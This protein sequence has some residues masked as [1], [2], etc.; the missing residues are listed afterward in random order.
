[1]CWGQYPTRS[2]VAEVK[3]LGPVKVYHRPGAEMH[4]QRKGTHCSMSLERPQAGRRGCMEGVA[5]QMEDAPSVDRGRDLS[6]AAPARR[7][8]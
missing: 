8:S 4:C 1:M 6:E 7:Q 3:S 2:G 5:A